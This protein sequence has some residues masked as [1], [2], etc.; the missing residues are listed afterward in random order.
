M[1]LMK[2]TRMTD[3]WITRTVAANPFQKMPDGN[4]RTCPLRLA[5]VHL[6]KPNPDAKN[7]DGTAKSVPSYECVGLMPPGAAEQISAA[8]WPDI[9]ATLTRQFPK[10]IAAN[11]QPFGLN[12]GWHADQGMKQQYA[13]YTPGL[14]YAPF[15]TQYKPQ[16]VDPAMNPIVDEGRVYAGVWAILS[17]NLYDYNNK[18]K[19]VGFGLQGVMIVAD[20]ERLAGGGPDPKTQFAG[21]R[22]DAKFDAAGA[23]GAMPAPSAMPPPA[24]IMPPP[25]MIGGTR[26]VAPAPPMAPPADTSMADMGL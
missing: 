10:Q 21:V 19:G 20:D 7:D 13:G 12:F 18:T 16:I 22:V 14:P 11:G 1:S 4:F 8:L 3:D 17:F 26:P 9:Y 23:F 15:R 6:M 25:T 2:N 5:F 24:S